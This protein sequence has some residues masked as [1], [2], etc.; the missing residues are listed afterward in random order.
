VYWPNIPF[1]SSFCVLFN[2]ITSRKRRISSR[3]TVIQKCS[4]MTVCLVL[5]K[6]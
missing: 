3:E 4:V 2:I 6:E 5:S 1:I